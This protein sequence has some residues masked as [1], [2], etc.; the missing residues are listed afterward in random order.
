VR[1]Q[2]AADRAALVSR[3]AERH[4]G[5]EPRVPFIV[6]AVARPV[7]CEACGREV[8]RGRI[9]EVAPKDES[10]DARLCVTC[11][12]RAMLDWADR[13]RAEAAVARRLAQFV[14]DEQPIG[15]VPPKPNTSRVA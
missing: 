5:S 14:G 10:T 13:R 9:V 6:L 3:W 12:R 11:G 2:R 8:S 4:R 15:A 1:R 7:I